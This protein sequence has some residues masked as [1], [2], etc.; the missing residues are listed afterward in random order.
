MLDHLE[1]EQKYNASAISPESFRNFCSERA[2][3]DS[4]VVSGYDI[5]YSHPADTNSFFRYR[6]GYREA[7]LTFKKKLSDDNNVMRIEHNLPLAGISVDR[8]KGF[9]KDMGYEFNSAIFKIN[10]VYQYPHHAMVYYV[11]Y[12]TRLVELGR[13]IEVE[14]SENYNWES[15][16]KAKSVLQNIEKHCIQLGLTPLNRVKESLF[17][18]FRRK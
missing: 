4:F 18:L 9:C 1:I 7:E 12:D 3:L 6:E 17:E 2:P 14:L 13:F 8:A 15:E 11:C 10:I 5:F 16:D